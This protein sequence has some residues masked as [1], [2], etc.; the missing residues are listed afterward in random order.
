MVH[1]KLLIT[2]IGLFSGPVQADS[3]ED[4]CC[5]SSV[6][7]VVP[8]NSY[9]SWKGKNHDYMLYFSAYCKRI[10]DLVTYVVL[11]LRNWVM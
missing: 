10:S 9:I 11:Y 5:F 7:G 8:A 6:F 2:V 1:V 3:A 4:G